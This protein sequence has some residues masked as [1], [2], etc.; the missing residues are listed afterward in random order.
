M[1]EFIKKNGMFSSVK[2]FKTV[3]YSWSN[4]NNNGIDNDN[5]TKNDDVKVNDVTD[6]DKT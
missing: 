2:G 3:R 4:D 6:D 1:L 5:D